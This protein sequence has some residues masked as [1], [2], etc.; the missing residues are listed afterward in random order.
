MAAVVAGERRHQIQAVD[1]AAQEH[2]H[3]GVVTVH[4]G[5][6]FLREQQAG[7]R[8][9]DRGGGA[10]GLEEFAPIET[11]MGHGGVLSGS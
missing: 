3:H 10:A 7:A 4:R 6:R 1:A 8:R 11:G 2:Q 5:L 9:A